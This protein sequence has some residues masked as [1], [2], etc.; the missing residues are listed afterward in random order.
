VD[1][2]AKLV[3]VTMIQLTAGD[4]LVPIVPVFENA[5]YQAIEE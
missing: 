3:A 2:K 1:P 4:R 5:T